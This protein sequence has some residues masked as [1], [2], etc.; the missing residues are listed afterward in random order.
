MDL[1]FRRKV[2]MSKLVLVI[3]ILEGEILIRGEMEFREKCG[4]EEEGDSGRGR[5]LKR[6]NKVLHWLLLIL[7]AC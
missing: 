5:C 2:E 3:I 6:S 7:L 1:L 4:G